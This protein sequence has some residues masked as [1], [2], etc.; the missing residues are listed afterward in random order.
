M[1]A[2]LL[3]VLVAAV[4]AGSGGSGVPAG[5]ARELNVH[6]S[7]DRLLAEQGGPALVWVLFQDKGPVD[8]TEAIKGLEQ[9]YNARA[10]QRRRLRRTAPG[11]FDERDLPV[12]PDYVLAVT[13][14]GAE[15][16]TASR[17]VNG[18][19]VLATKAH[20]RAIAALPF[21]SK[22]QPVRRIGH[23]PA[24]GG[25]TDIDPPDGGAAAGA[26]SFYG[27]AEEQLAQINV[28]ALHEQGYTGS[29]VI[30]GSLDTGFATTHE[31]F[32]YPGHPLQVVAAWD[33]LNDDPDVGIEPGDLPN[34]HEHGTYILGTMA[35]YNPNVLVAG[36]YDASYILA[37]VEDVA[38]EYLAEEHLFVAGLEFIE[39]NGGDVATSSVVMYDYYPQDQL[40]GL[41]S[42]MTIGINT[43]TANGLH[44]LQGAGNQGH[45]SDPATSTLLPPADGFQAITCGS[46][47]SAGVSAWFTSDGPT[48]DGRVKPELMA[49]GVNTRTVNANADNGYSEI[50]GASVA[51]PT[52]AGAVACVVQVHPEWTVDQMRW[53]LIHTA[54]IYVTS[55]T[56]DP[57][58]IRGYG[59][60]DILAAAGSTPPRPGDLDEDGVVGILD[61]LT[62][63]S[64]W[65]PCPEP[66]PP[67]CLGDVDTDCDVGV[68]D[69]LILLANWG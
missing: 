21:V 15:L 7:V 41:T 23:A 53:A 67:H 9:T 33:F 14:T 58:Y 59:I 20:V 38:G 62:L 57:L 29:G 17:W 10:I 63:L 49:R 36:G 2:L 34:Q 69:F 22:V 27:L 42:V 25:P 56:F 8:A 60:S 44:C 11:L 35:A 61:F 30:I 37:K 6:R 13:R 26:G 24:P 54:D 31:A 4:V 5:V 64:Q 39:A 12:H 19:S 45:D 51:T 46:V 18:V 48:A 3:S 43:A 68:T 16:R 1:R 50:N 47:D 32:N 28:I 40:D 66:C 65:G 55:G 52:T